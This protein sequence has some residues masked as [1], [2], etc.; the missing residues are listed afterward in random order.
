MSDL[1]F[2]V[3]V[4]ANPTLRIG[5][6]TGRVLIVAE[7]RDDVL[8]ESGATDRSDI[9][10]S[11]GGLRLRSAKGGTT[12]VELRCPEGANVVV[13]AG[14]GRVELEGTFGDVKIVT[15]SGRISIDT[16]T[17]VDARSVSGSISIQRCERGCRA[18][19]K[20][21]KIKIGQAGA[22]KVSTVSGRITLDRIDGLASITTV[23][24]RVQVGAC[25]GDNVKVKTMS[26]SVRVEVPSD[27]KPSTSLRSARSKTRCD[28]DMGDDFQI[29][30][31]S[32]TGSIEVVPGL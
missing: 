26:G 12:K 29:D 1:P 2:T 30:V 16:A 11:D 14:T 9:D 32:M 18:S 15:A 21:G 27:L 8:V 25:G 3:A 5:T 23:T 6:R 28:C 17:R 4:S 13:G 10:A 31:A 22:A 24:G 19:S 7:H 20:S